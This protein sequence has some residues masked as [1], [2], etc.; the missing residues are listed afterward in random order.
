M[1]GRI[2]GNG[3]GILLLLSSNNAIMWVG[4]VM[5]GAGI[6]GNGNFP[7]SMTALVFGRR[8]FPVY[9]SVVNTIVGV[10]RSC[11]FALLAILRSMSSGYT[12]PYT[13]FAIVALIGGLMVIPVKVTAAVE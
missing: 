10:V 8:D 3:I 2:A 6:G 12:L 4:V 1:A 11:S 7:P 9:Y 13:V 5:L